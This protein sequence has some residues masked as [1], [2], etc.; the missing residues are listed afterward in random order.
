MAVS[1]I[2]NNAT[3]ELTV[4]LDCD[5][6]KMSKIMSSI[7]GEIHKIIGEYTVKKQ[8]ILSQYSIL[9]LVNNEYKD[10]RISKITKYPF[11]ILCLLIQLD[12]ERAKKTGDKIRISYDYI[13]EMTGIDKVSIRN[14]IRYL[15]DVKIYSRIYPKDGEK[16]KEKEK[17]KGAGFGIFRETNAVYIYV[18]DVGNSKYMV[19]FS[20]NI[21]ASAPEGFSDPRYMDYNRIIKISK[22]SPPRI[23]ITIQMMCVFRNRM[24]SA[25]EYS[26]ALVESLIEDSKIP[27]FL[28]RI[29]DKSCFKKSRIRQYPDDN[30]N[31]NNNILSIKAPAPATPPLP[32]TTGNRKPFL[33]DKDYNKDYVATYKT[34]TDT[35]QKRDRYQFRRTWIKASD[36]NI[37]FFYKKLSSI[38]VPAHK[39]KSPDV[40]A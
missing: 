27:V 2:I 32:I 19:V 25:T 24:E 30:D 29:I 20:C 11:M 8:P 26:K 23:I 15:R 6:R 4:L 39:M 5:H 34:I 18:E 14:A 12:I 10:L 31:N 22:G 9:K 21:L 16:E 35:F 36:K 28:N 33:V 38:D 7:T 3:K 13:A 1:R 40:P 37:V 17:E